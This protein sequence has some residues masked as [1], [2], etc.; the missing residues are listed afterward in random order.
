MCMLG[1]ASSWATQCALRCPLVW[2]SFSIGTASRKISKGEREVDVNP[3]L[4]LYTSSILPT[5]GLGSGLFATSDSAQ[6]VRGMPHRKGDPL[7]EAIPRY[8]LGVAHPA[9]VGDA[10]ELPIGRAHL[11]LAIERRVGLRR[12]LAVLKKP[13]DAPVRLVDDLGHVQ[14]L[15]GKI[16]ESR[17]VLEGDAPRGRGASRRALSRAALVAAVPGASF[18]RNS[19][20]GPAQVLAQRLTPDEQRIGPALIWMNSGKQ[21]PPHGPIGNGGRV[22]ARAHASAL[23]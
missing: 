13:Q 18:A 14:G 8:A 4:L 22:D 3:L 21:T 5:A 7:C 1:V 20:V 6:N 15:E 17:V 19:A 2:M 10:G 9:L 11:L 12:L 16:L 23:C